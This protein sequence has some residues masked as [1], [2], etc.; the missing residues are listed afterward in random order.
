MGG[1]EVDFFAV[2]HPTMSGE[3]AT[4]RFKRTLFAVMDKIALV[5]AKEHQHVGR[6]PIG[7][8]HLA[9]CTTHKRILVSKG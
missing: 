4:A 8:Q 6:P 2:W 9:K 3:N 7:S 5:C 1:S